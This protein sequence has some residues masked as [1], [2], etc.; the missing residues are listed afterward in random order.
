LTVPIT[1]GKGGYRNCHCNQ[2]PPLPK[3]IGTVIIKQSPS[4]PK[5]IGTV[6]VSSRILM[7]VPITLGKGGDWLQ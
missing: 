6:I 3:V 5:V 4:L 1:I 2:S 7:T